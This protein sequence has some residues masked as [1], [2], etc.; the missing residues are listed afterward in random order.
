MNNLKDGQLKNTKNIRMANSQLY[1]SELLEIL[2]K[3]CL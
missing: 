2:I 1:E 3:K